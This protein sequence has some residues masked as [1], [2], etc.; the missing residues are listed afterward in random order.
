[1]NEAKDKRS[2]KIITLG[3]FFF[4]FLSV[5]LLLYHHYQKT[6]FELAWFDFLLQT[7]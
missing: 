3:F 5:A 1:M 2:K 6:G 4:F 7:I